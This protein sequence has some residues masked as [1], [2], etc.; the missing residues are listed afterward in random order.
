ML[1]CCPPVLRGGNLPWLTGCCGPL[2]PVAVWQH[3]Q[4]VV[5]RQ[6]MRCI[7]RWRSCVA[8]GFRVTQ[9]VPCWPGGCAVTCQPLSTTDG[10]HY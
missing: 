5:A 1:Q 6:A 9:R 3:Q 7:C 4:A 2:Q 8:G 10:A